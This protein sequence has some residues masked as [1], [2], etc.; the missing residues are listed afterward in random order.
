MRIDL[1]DQ[2]LSGYVVELDLA[3]SSPEGDAPVVAANICGEDGIEFIAQLEHPLCGGNA[4]KYDLSVSPRLTSGSQQK[5]AIPAK[6]E[7]GNLALR[8]CKAP[9]RLEGICAVEPDLPVTGN[10]QKRRVGAHGK[11][12]GCWITLRMQTRLPT[13]SRGQRSGARLEFFGNPLLQIFRRE[14]NLLLYLPLGSPCFNPSANTLD[15]LFGDGGRLR[16]H[17]RLYRMRDGG[18]KRAVT[19]I[20]GI[21]HRARGTSLHHGRISR[22]VEFALRIIFI[23]A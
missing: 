13:Q 7:H 16:G 18:I 19:Q 9:E 8:K 2:L 14:S 6:A 22:K 10:G 3:R 4:P 17:R 21:D 1:G 12:P 23:V 11:R 5:G 20:A 15:R